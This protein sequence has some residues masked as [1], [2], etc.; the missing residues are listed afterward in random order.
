MDLYR[1][2]FIIIHTLSHVLHLFTQVISTISNTHSSQKNRHSHLRWYFEIHQKLYRW[3]EFVLIQSYE[4]TCP[5]V[6]CLNRYC[7]TCSSLT[8]WLTTKITTKIWIISVLVYWQFA[9]SPPHHTVDIFT[10]WPPRWHLTIDQQLLAITR[11][12]TGC[13]QRE[14]V[15]QG[16]V[17]QQRD[18][19]SHWK[20]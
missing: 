3:T 2:E 13:P 11:L 19:R 17:L 15:S 18:L 16:R 5:T 20:A 10:S 4:C 14:V 7:I 1:S 8:M 6:Q 9:N 12:P